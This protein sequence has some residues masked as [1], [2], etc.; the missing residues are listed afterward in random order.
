MNISSKYQLI[1]EKDGW[2]I[3]APEYLPDGEA[4]ELILNRTADGKYRISDDYQAFDWLYVNGVTLEDNNE[5]YELAQKKASECGVT[6][7]KSQI[8][9]ISDMLHLM[10]NVVIITKAIK[11][12]VEIIREKN[13]VDN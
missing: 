3:V 5:L 6:M 2:R 9:I 4:I 8:Y 10:E 13:N 11:E 12:V 7:N 1:K